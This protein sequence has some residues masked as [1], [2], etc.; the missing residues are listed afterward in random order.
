M[1]MIEARLAEDARR[2]AVREAKV[3]EA[4]CVGVIF[5]CRLPCIGLLLVYFRVLALIFLLLYFPATK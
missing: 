5:L 2:E 3:C 1:Q 4:L